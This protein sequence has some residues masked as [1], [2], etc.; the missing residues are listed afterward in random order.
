MDIREIRKRRL[1]QLIISRFGGV[2]ARLAEK[3]GR[4]SSYVARVLS[5]NS[6]HSRNIGEKLAREIEVACD[7][8]TGY[9]DTP[10]DYKHLG[11][12]PG[13]SHL[14]HADPGE[15]ISEVRYLPEQA[16]QDEA[17][18]IPKMDL[19]MPKGT[20]GWEA[21][22][23]YDRM[24]SSIGLHKSWI[25]QHL[26]VTDPY[27][28]RI[29]NASTGGTMMPSIAHGDSLLVDIGIQAINQDGVYLLSI[30]GQPAIRRAQRGLDGLKIFTDNRVYEMV[31]P[32]DRETELAIHG[33]VVY[34]W[35]GG[36]L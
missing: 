19:T 24:V 6:E 26:S 29:I 4:Q 15:I 17:V 32:F 21:V 16:V 14:S 2:M 31:V 25:R 8:A 27:N 10:F 34:C 1:Q 35:S 3:I 28:L 30:S 36:P 5:E 22:T 9:L 23:E 20:G 13:G 7:L 12:D 33:K 18:L 11:F